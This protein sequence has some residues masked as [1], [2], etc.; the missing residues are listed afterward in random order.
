MHQKTAFCDYSWKMVKWYSIQIPHTKLYW[1][2]EKNITL[3]VKAESMIKPLCD[4]K[5]FTDIW[6]MISLDCILFL[7][8][9]YYKKHGKLI[10][11]L[12]H[13]DIL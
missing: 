11:Q 12:F 3:T 8:F 6:E 2:L 7:E 1:K 13:F 9:D 10:S 4:G 5:N